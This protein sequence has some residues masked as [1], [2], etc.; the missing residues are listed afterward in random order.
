M[1]AADRFTSRAQIPM[2]ILS[3]AF[4]AVLVTPVINDHLSP[5]WGRTLAVAN[6]VLWVAFAAEY[7]IRLALAPKRMTFIRANVLDL[8]IVAV[9]MFRPLRIVRL[10]AIG[11]KVTTGKLQPVGVAIRVFVTAAFIVLLGAVGVLDVERHATGSSIH[12]F[13]DALWWAFT[14]VT[15]V[16]YGDKFPVTAEGRVIA[17]LVMMTGIAILGVATALIASWF[18]KLGR[19]D[20]QTQNDRIEA[21]MDAILALL[22]DAELPDAASHSM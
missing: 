10:V 12:T 9:P 16:G 3:V 22:A 13:G 17:V 11:S 15:T 19:S 8:F 21:K 14:T 4:I 18:V 7:L 2:L 1:N 5:G 20:T 6:I